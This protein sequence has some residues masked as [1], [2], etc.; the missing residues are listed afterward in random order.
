M[1]DSILH[2]TVGATPTEGLDLRHELRLVKAAML[3]ADKVKLCSVSSSA[4][5]A[6]GC[7]ADIEQ[8]DLYE[9]VLQ[10]SDTIGSD[11]AEI[12]AA[13][14]LHKTLKRKK[15]RTKDELIIFH[16]LES[17]LRTAQDRL[18][19]ASEDLILKADGAGLATALDSGV[20]E[21]Q[22]FDFSSD[23]VIE[24]YLDAIAG[25]VLSDETY[26]LFDQHTG[27]IVDS[28]IQS[29][30]IVPL[31]TTIPRATQ[32][33]L[34]SSLFER[35]PLF[36]TATIDE[37]VDIR[38]ELD[39]PLRRFRSAIIRISKEI[40]SAP[41][42]KEFPQEVEQIF[43]QYVDP[44]VLEIEESCKSNSLLSRFVTNSA[45]YGIPSSSVL[46]LMLAHVGNSPEMIAAL[47]GASAFVGG[48]GA[49][50]SKHRAEKR[51]IQKNELYFYYKV[52]QTLSRGH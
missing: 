39:A 48:A 6:L 36:D 22:W 18:K 27:S 23:T 5:I 25:A 31:G 51:K 45:T 9:L 50:L 47:S 2:I 44:A 4:V 12:M 20:V 8:D 28:A 3:Y 38:K 52:N 14:T 40:D 1:Q 33:G 29:G 24:D 30:L 42:N 16:K 26:P 17:G 41:W 19:V 46:G 49:A 32:V 13:M 35:L 21:L 7:L 15:R 43:Y 10:V 11:K 34:S 37:I